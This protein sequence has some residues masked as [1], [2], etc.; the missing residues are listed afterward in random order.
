MSIS[1][2]LRF[3][4]LQYHGY[5]CFYCGRRPPAVVLEI[6]HRIARARGGCDEFSNLVPACYDCNRSK[7]A[8]GLPQWEILGFPDWQSWQTYEHEWK[9]RPD[10][11]PWWM[12]PFPP[13]GGPVLDFDWLSV[14]LSMP[15]V[16]RRMTDVSEVPF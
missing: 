8:S 6:E 10:E 1:K 12:E 15:R 2:K 9:C 11:L 4:V 7:G 14:A 16:D 3:Q 5:A 13:I